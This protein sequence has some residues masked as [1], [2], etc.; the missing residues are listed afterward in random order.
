MAKRTKDLVDEI[1]K[2]ADDLADELC[3]NPQPTPRFRRLTRTLKK[4]VIELAVR[5]DG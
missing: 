1:E 5:F 3:N 2:A 4:L